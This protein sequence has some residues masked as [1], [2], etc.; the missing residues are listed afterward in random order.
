MYYPTNFFNIYDIL[1]EYGFVVIELTTYDKKIL[2]RYEFA[3]KNDIPYGQIGSF[4]VSEIRSFLTD[5]DDSGIV[6]T[7]ECPHENIE[8]IMSHLKQHALTT[9]VIQ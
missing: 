9:E 7:V 4:K 2:G 1:S 8:K 5:D 6:L 3:C